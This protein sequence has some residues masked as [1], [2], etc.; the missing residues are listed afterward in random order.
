M[1]PARHVWD[2]ILLI[3]ISS[4]PRGAVSQMAD[5]G[6]EYCEYIRKSMLEMFSMA[7]SVFKHTTFVWLLHVTWSGPCDGVC[8]PKYTSGRGVALVLDAATM[9]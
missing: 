2:L 5:D 4:I 8:E 9:N 7:R 1:M 6:S 3:L